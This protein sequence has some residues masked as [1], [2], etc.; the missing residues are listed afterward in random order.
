MSN[1]KIDSSD[2]FVRWQTN[3]REQVSFTNNLF[4]VISVGIAGFFFNLIIQQNFII[5]CENKIVFR[6]GI[7]LLIISILLGTLTSISRTID[8]RLTL[9][10]I[11]VEL[12][13]GNNLDDLKYWKKTFGKLTWFFFYSQIIVL[14]VSLICLGISFYKLYSFKF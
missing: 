1:F 12:E 8:F 11:K 4:T 5:S 2:R 9:K 7:I 14:F 13:N 10:K 3:L 6:L